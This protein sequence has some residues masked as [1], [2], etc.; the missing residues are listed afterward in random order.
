[1]TSP[2]TTIATSTEKIFQAL[3]LVMDPHLVALTKVQTFSYFRYY[4]SSS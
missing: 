4:N 1:M 2:D 3:M